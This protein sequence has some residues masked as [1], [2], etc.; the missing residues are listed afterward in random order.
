MASDAASVCVAT[1]TSSIAVFS[2]STVRLHRHRRHR[3]RADRIR[4][5][6]DSTPPERVSPLVPMTY[7]G[8][9]YTPRSRP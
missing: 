6:H 9:R 2:A 3:R 7:E 1:V 4:V 5:T 8:A